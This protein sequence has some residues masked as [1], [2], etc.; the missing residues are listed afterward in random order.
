MIVASPTRMKTRDKMA[1][2]PRRNSPPNGSPSS[3]KNTLR[4]VVMFLAALLWL[5]VPIAVFYIFHKPFPQ[6]T[7]ERLRD[8]LI[9]LL[10]AGWILWI[11]IGLGRGIF[12]GGVFS[13][14]EGIA[15]SGAFG[16]AVLSVLFLAIA[17]AGILTTIAAVVLC[18]GLTIAASITLLREAAWEK[19]PDGIFPDRN[20]FS[21]FVG[22]FV[23]VSLIL[24]L[25][26]ALAPPTAWDALVYHLRL[27]QEYLAAG[28]LFISGDS[29]FREMPQTGE[30][31]YAAATALTGRPETAAV[32][33]WAAALLAVV[34][35][36]G[37]ARRMGLRH[38]LLP[39]ALL[40][41][42]DTLAR[43]MGWGYVD[44]IAALF[45]V[46]ALAAVTRKESGARWTLLAGAF[47]GMAAGTKY[48]DGIVLAVLILA[49][50]SRKEWK[51]FLKDAA[52]LSAGF[53]VAFS[54]WIL[55][56]LAL[57][58]NPL[59]P[60]LDSAPLEAAK[61]EFF[62]GRALESAGWMAAV[63]PILQ[64][65]IGAYG[66]LPFGVT[67]GPLLLAFLPGALVRREAQPADGL[68]LKLSAGS[69]L[70][71]WGACALGG[72]F[73]ASLMQP[74]LYLSLFPGIALLAAYGFEG[75]WRIRLM[76]IRLGAVAAVLSALVF[77]VQAAG[78]AQSWISSGAP[79]YLAG[80]L[81]RQEYLE[82]NLGWYLPAMDYQ[83]TLPEGS[84]VLM[85][86]EPR[87]LYC[88]GI[89]SE[90]AT[91]DRWYLAMRSG[92]T[93]E[94]ILAGWRAAGWT[95]ILISD[96]GAEFER[97]WRSEYVAADWEAL[98][99]LRS[100]LA[101]L[102]RFGCSETR[103]VYTLYSLSSTD[104]PV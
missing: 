89:C 4:A 25:G 63:M 92:R 67:I 80:S 33:G 65:T 96:A 99:R 38:G 98:D 76:P 51:R 69:A 22:I 1:E 24:S 79:S 43:S 73:S 17:W 28:S 37:T 11:G 62:T 104:A 20:G 70:L 72:F 101:V 35:L 18:V 97:G 26:V 55:R 53:L 68:L 8:V 19:F 27:P 83:R 34:G 75:L 50:L 90:D 56:G 15:L 6:A 61:M 85:L 54:P 81:S 57:W 59:P 13:P 2:Q 74:R 100:Q 102:E 7:W 41:S 21:L 36:T 42:G 49:V 77:A 45:G 87:G 40:L 82:N 91:I 12:R 52:L 29:L 30:M 16:L 48:T 94:E 78:F 95:H 14:L 71:F 3:E 39:A 44:W 46:A 58:S 64:S 66:A 86:W 32:L 9:D 23:A 5:V 88:G 84:R 103:C 10:V 47:A 31:L 60:I 93:V